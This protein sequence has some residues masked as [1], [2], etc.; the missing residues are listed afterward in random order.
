MKY[1]TIGFLAVLAGSG[2]IF[3]PHEYSPFISAIFIGCGTGLFFWKDKISES[4]KDK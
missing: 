4:E 3:I 2:M 1:S